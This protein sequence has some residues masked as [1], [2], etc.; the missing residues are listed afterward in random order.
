M[1]FNSETSNK[2]PGLQLVLHPDANCKK[3]QELTVLRSANFIIF[4]DR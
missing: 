2:D 1:K 3:D 4:P